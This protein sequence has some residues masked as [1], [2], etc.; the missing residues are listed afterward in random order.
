[1]ETKSNSLHFIFT[2]DILVQK[3]WSEMDNSFNIHKKLRN[4]KLGG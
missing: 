4:N 3:L 2:A 1:M